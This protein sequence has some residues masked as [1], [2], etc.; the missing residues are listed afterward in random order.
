[1]NWLF[2]SYERVD[3]VKANKLVFWSDFLKDAIY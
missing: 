3:D 2:I 1:M